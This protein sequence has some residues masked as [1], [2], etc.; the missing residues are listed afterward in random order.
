MRDSDDQCGTEPFDVV[1]AAEQAVVL[2]SAVNPV[3]VAVGRTGAPATTLT[4]RITDS[5]DGAF[6]DVARIT[7]Q[8]VQASATPVGGGTTSTCPVTIVS[9]TPATSTSPGF[10]D[11]SCTIPAGLKADVYELAVSVT[12]SFAGSDAGLLGVFDAKARGVSGAGSVL[13]GNGNTLSYGLLASGEGKKVKGQVSLIERIPAGTIVNRVKGVALS[14][15]SVGTGSPRTAI[16]DGKAVVNGVGNYAYVLTV[17]DAATDTLALKVTAPAGAPAVP[18]LTFTA[19]PVRA[20]S[21]IT[22]V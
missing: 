22:I 4:A 17:T 2:W 11:V 9:R 6:G 19:R 10:V 16:L 8:T 5:A 7:A 21:A 14:S 3:S 20:G 1:V 12:G 15:L 13:L 18:S